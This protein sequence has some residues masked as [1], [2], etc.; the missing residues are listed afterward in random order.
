MYRKT[1]SLHKATKGGEIKVKF[2]NL[3]NLQLY[4]IYIKIFV[5][6]WAE[7]LNTFDSDTKVQVG[8]NSLNL[9]KRVLSNFTPL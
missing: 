8:Y 3:E 7:I 9:L 5:S 6:V 1:R 4:N 2:R